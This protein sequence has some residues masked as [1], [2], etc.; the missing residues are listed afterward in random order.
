MPRGGPEP[1]AAGDRER[2]MEFLAGLVAEG[3]AEVDASRCLSL[4][5]WLALG[6]W[7]RSS[8]RDALEQRFVAL[9]RRL[10]ASGGA[11]TP[12]SMQRL[13]LYTGCLM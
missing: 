1:G 12:A 8:H 9:L 11:P 4:L 10:V 7:L 5:Q 13:A 6:P 3:R 2:A